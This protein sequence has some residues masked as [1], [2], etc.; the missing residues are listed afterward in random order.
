MPTARRPR[1]GDRRSEWSGHKVSLFACDG[2]RPRWFREVVF[3]RGLNAATAVAAGVH[4][5]EGKQLHKN[6]AALRVRGVRSKNLERRQVTPTALAQFWNSS[7]GNTCDGPLADDMVFVENDPRDCIPV[8]ITNPFRTFSI[9]GNT[10]T[11][12]CKCPEI[13][14]GVIRTNGPYCL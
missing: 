1:T 3:E 4:Q 13:A 5:L 6:R 7:N 10:L 14:C 11:R 12:V 2:P 9:S 8:T